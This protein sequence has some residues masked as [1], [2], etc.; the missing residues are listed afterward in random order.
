M[1]AKCGG[2]AASR[3]AW[4]F[5]NSQAVFSVDRAHA[6]E[7]PNSLG[8]QE[9]SGGRGIYGVT[10]TI[11]AEQ[12]G[13]SGTVRR[14]QSRPSRKKNFAP[15]SLGFQEQSGGLLPLNISATANRRTA[16]D[17][18]NSQAVQ[19]LVQFGNTICR[20]AWDF[21]NSQAVS[22]RVGRTTR[23]L[24]NSLGFQEQS[25]G[26]RGG[27]ERKWRRGPN[28]LGFQE[29]S[30]GSSGEVFYGENWPNSLGF[31]EQSGGKCGYTLPASSAAE[32]LGISGTVRRTE[33]QFL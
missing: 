29:Q 6:V 1:H 14:N 25:G 12:L 2:W 16:W 27:E 21:R 8:F 15:N 10:T 19:K 28:S 11:T 9:Q 20:T 5:R 32:Q 33:S 13:I 23:S 26:C 22:P 18:R 30:G 17:F 7:K 31:Q 3:T 24:P 4:D